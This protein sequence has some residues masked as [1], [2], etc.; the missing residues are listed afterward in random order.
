MK[1]LLVAAIAL[2]LAGVQDKTYDLRL[3]WKP[4]KGHRSELAET[5][6]L[7]LSV[8]V[9]GLGEV[10]AQSERSEYQRARNR[11]LGRRRGR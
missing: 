9:A 8:T 10:V 4:V 11:R 3:E 5:S 1:S 6:A 7:K 2:T